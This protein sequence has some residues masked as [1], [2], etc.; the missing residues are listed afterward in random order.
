MSA[1]TQFQPGVQLYKYTLQSYIGGGGF[2]SV[3]L[4]K[5]QAIDRDVAVK[6]LDAS[7]ASIVDQLREAQIG[8]RMDHPN[9]VKVH[10]A[11]VMPFNETSLVLIAMD[12]MANG[13]ILQKVNSGNFIPLK[14]ALGIIVDILRGLEYLHEQGIYHNDIKPKNILIG[15]NGENKLTD[16]GISAHSNGNHSVPATNSYKLHIAPEILNSNHINIQTDIYQVGL[17]AFRLINGI[18]SL[19]QKFNTLGEQ[20]YYQTVQKSGIIKD[21]DYELHVPNNLRTLISKAVH[22]TP[23][24][25]FQSSREMR[26]AIERLAYPGQWTYDP[27]GN[28]YG[29][30]GTHTY[31]FEEHPLSKSQCDFIAFKKNNLTGIERR[32]S[33]FCKLKVKPVDALKL[34]KKFI[35]H[36]IRGF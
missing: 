29:I 30:T 1:C 8:N 3:W 23:N 18:G 10:Y 9:L 19:R 4:A 6:I 15:N 31:R 34:K 36:V 33:N 16:Y 12:Y 35:N 11:D 26:R 20:N 5:D 14:E 32:I 13:S 7:Q 21:K 24:Q 25:R 17:T 27:Q 22:I 2:G 28:F